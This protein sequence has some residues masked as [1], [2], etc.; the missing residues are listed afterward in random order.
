LTIEAVVVLL[1]DFRDCEMKGRAA[2]GAVFSPDADI[3]ITARGDG[4]C[5]A[6]A[7]KSGETLKAKLEK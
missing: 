6:V 2:A 7:A 5:K 1:H 3:T 4:R